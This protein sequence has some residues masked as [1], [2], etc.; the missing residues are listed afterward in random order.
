MTPITLDKLKQII[1]EDPAFNVD[2]IEIHNIIMTQ[3]NTTTGLGDL[4]SLLN[5]LCVQVTFGS[6]HS[7]SELLIRYPGHL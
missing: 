4:D 1:H 7:H 2:E 6:L 5:V 3:K